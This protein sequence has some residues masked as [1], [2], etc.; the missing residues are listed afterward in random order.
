MPVTRT[1]PRVRTDLPHRTRCVGRLLGTPTSSHTQGTPSRCAER[2]GSY[3]LK[4]SPTFIDNQ[5]S[6]WAC[7]PSPIRV[8]LGSAAQARNWIARS[9]SNQSSAANAT[10]D[11]DE[12]AQ[13]WRAIVDAKNSE[14]EQ[15]KL[16]LDSILDILKELQRQ[17]V[18]LPTNTRQHAYN[19]LPHR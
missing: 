15:F 1:V 12:E 17:G 3:R 8:L 16:E 2:S 9:T 11:L 5:K 13:R 14:I 18:V 19:G 10:A 4:V 6:D 7:R